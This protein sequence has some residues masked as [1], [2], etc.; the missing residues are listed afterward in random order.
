VRVGRRKVKD[1]SPPISTDGR[2]LYARR[3]RE[4]ERGLRSAIE[5]QGRIVDIGLSHRIAAAATLAVQVEVIR[6][7]RAHGEEIHD[8][9]VTRYLFG[10]DR[11]LNRLGLKPSVLAPAPPKPAPK[12]SA[13]VRQQTS[14]R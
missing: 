8:E 12:L 10:L 14:I 2:R 13:I 5:Q 7:K 6:V 11:A 1:P 4:I 9:V 3:I